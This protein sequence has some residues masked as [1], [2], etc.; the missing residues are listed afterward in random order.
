MRIKGVLGI[1]AVIALTQGV[2]LAPVS[3]SA[4]IDNTLPT[5]GVKVTAVAKGDCAQNP[6]TILVTDATT[7]CSIEIAITPA[8][9]YA[10][11]SL[12]RPISKTSFGVPFFVSTDAGK[13][14][15]SRKGWATI[16]VRKTTA[17]ASACLITS[18]TQKVLA[19]VTNSKDGGRTFTTQARS[20]AITVTYQQNLPATPPVGFCYVTLES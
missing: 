17:F 10:D 4:R 12:F 15:V 19:Q 5:G 13:I 20:K 16:E 2:Q 18:G 1:A 8:K 14:S 6:T 11:V 9:R 7:S 3:A